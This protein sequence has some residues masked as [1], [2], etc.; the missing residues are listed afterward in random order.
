MSVLLLAGLLTS[1]VTLITVVAFCFRREFRRA[2]RVAFRWGIC[3]ATYA[4]IL[5]AAMTPHESALRV[6][7]PYCD[8]DMCMSVE[9][10]TRTPEQMGSSY[11]FGIRLF[12]RAN[13]G[14]RS[15]KGASVYLTDERN[16]RFLAAH[17]PAATPFD[18]VE[19][20]KSVSTSLTFHVPSDA[21][22]LAFAARMDRIH[23]ASFI[24]GSGDLLH[25]PRLKLRLQWL[26][27]DN[28][29]RP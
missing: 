9:S 6:G 16:R 5:V 28:G 20:G 21:H 27:I 25:N 7:A 8:D 2:G 13:H 19:P 12:S 4:A 29:G 11:R 15:A 24:I 22:T 10:I 14:P 17:D 26:L 3:A 23:Y 18:V 1:V